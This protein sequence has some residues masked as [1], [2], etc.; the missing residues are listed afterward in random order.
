[1][2]NLILIGSFIAMNKAIFLFTLILLTVAPGAAQSRAHHSTPTTSSFLEADRL[3]TFGE[4]AERDK[5]SLSV[6]ERS[7]AADGD[8]Y[9]WL[10]RAAR[11]SYFVGE[12]AA[13]AEKLRYFEKGIETGQRAIARE[14]N[15]VEG[16]FWLAVNYGGYSEQKGVFKAL[17]TVKKIRA[18]METVLKLNDS[19]QDGGAYLALGEM[20]RQLPRIIGG[21]ITRSI[22]R[23]EQGMKIA[24]QNLEI[25]Y[26]LAQAYQEAGRKED[27]RREYQAIID[28]QSASNSQRRLQEKARLKLAKL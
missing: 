16:H 21:N 3:F 17:L 26:S 10:W 11:V 9:Q 4:N 7:L 6:I 8:N 13:K 1:L 27:A 12:D 25:K 28:K 19:Y 22:S 14:P 2:R 18:E 24:P 23:L 20:D 5:Q 15:A